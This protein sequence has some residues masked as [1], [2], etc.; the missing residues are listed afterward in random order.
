MPST[1]GASQHT[2]NALQRIAALSAAHATLFQKCWVLS[3]VA[4]APLIYLPF[5]LHIN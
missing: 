1:D 5:P 2:E 4:A 3:L